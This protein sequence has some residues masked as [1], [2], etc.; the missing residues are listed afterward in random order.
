MYFYLKG[1]IMNNVEEIIESLFLGR[2]IKEN[3][4][5]IMLKKTDFIDFH[6]S[7]QASAG[8]VSLINLVSS[9]NDKGVKMGFLAWYKFEIQIVNNGK[10][11]CISGE[12]TMSTARSPLTPRLFKTLDSAFNTFCMHT[13]EITLI[14]EG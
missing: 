3:E 7:I 5:L 10:E 1:N 14:T 8:D 12:A 6:S 9:Y 2:K 13:E 11:V 4:N